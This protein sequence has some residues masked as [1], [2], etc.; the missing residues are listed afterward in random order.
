LVKGSSPKV[1]IIQLIL[2]AILNDAADLIRGTG[3]VRDWV[4][5][6]PM[7]AMYT[8]VRAHSAH[9]RPETAGW[10]LAAPVPAWSAI[11]IQT[12]REDGERNRCRSACQ[13]AIDPPAEAQLRAKMIHDPLSRIH[14]WGFLSFCHSVLRV[15]SSFNS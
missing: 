5:G 11:S 3:Y 8:K 15:S 1:R 2:V 12:G 13:T 6:L 4:E 14:Y 10:S 7:R 9:E